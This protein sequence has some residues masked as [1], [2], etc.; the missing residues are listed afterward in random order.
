MKE[1]YEKQIQEEVI[2][3]QIYIE[4]TEVSTEYVAINDNPEESYE[5]IFDEDANRSS[6]LHG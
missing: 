6:N 2:K 5:S 1:Y 4:D 3:T